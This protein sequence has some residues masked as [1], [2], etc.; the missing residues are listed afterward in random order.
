MTVALINTEKNKLLASFLAYKTDFL[1][2]SQLY[3]INVPV[4]FL[5]LQ[6]LILIHVEAM[7]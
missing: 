2:V 3:P 5:Q 4:T 1:K 6:Q 7:T